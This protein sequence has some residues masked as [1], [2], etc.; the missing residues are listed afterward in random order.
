MQTHPSFPLE[1]NSSTS[2]GG[3]AVVIHD[4]VAILSMQLS[5]ECNQ[6]MLIG[7][8]I[9]TGNS[10]DSQFPADEAQPDDG[11]IVVRTAVVGSHEMP[12]IVADITW[13]RAV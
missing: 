3:D 13:T 11:Q 5:T 1:D 4:S 6:F 12:L 7:E 8:R 9:L 10:I 2:V